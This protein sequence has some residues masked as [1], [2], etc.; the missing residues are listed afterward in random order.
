MARPRDDARRFFYNYYRFRLNPRVMVV[1]D[2]EAFFGKFD[3]ALRI[4]L[5][6][7]LS[8][9]PCTFHAARHLPCSLRMVMPKHFIFE[10]KFC[11]RLPAWAKEMIDRYQ[12]PQLALSKYTMSLDN[13]QTY[14]NDRRERFR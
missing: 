1:Y 9:A 13:Y 11:G 7:N 12:M 6:K 10:P 8:R 4:T 2:R 5:D 3:P 14:K